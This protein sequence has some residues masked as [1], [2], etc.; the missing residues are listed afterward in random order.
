MGGKEAALTEKLGPCLTLTLPIRRLFKDQE[1]WRLEKLEM[2]TKRIKA[3][4]LMKKPGSACLEGGLEE[5]AGKGGALCK[6]ERTARA[7]TRARTSA[8]TS[9]WC[10]G[11]RAG[12]W[13]S[14]GFGTRAWLE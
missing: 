6:T 4:I 13:A 9:P 2:A 1:G 5:A 8:R 11:W 3:K 7:R 14:R 12:L 10:Q